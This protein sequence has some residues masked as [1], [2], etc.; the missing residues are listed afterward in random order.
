MLVASNEAYARMRARARTHTHTH[1]HILVCVTGGPLPW[2]TLEG[3]EALLGV[4]LGDTH[5]VVQ[6]SCKN[7]G[8]QQCH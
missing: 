7:D 3:S 8:I 4:V 1:T 2:L 5:G 6:L